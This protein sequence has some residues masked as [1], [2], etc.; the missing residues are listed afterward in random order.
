[1]KTVTR[2]TRCLLLCV[3]F[4]LPAQA[5]EIRPAVMTVAVESGRCSVE[6]TLNLEALLAGV[7]PE[8]RDTDQSPNSHEYASLRALPPAALRDRWQEFEAHF[9]AGMDIRADGRRL[10]SRVV[11]IEIPAIDDTRLAR[12]TRLKLE[13]DLP[14]SASELRFAYAAAFGSS[15]WRVPGADGRLQAVWLQ[16]GRASDA[17][18]IG[19][20]LRAP[21]RFEIATQ[22]TALGFTHILPKGLDHILFVLGL[23]LLGTTLAPLLWQ[24]TAFTVAHTIT[25]ALSMYGVVALSPALVEPLIAASIVVVAVE[26]MFT[27]R[28]H[29]WRVFVVFGFGLLHGLG[30][31]GVLSEIGLPREEFVTGLI[32]F[33]V[34]VEIGQLAVIAL[35]W[36]LLRYPFGAQPWYRTRVVLPLSALIALT[37]LYWTLERIGF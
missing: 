8:H 23:F 28:L 11:V 32:A 20:G 3:A 14:N 15:V 5:H 33:N 4:V 16:G 24:V 9:L 18:V 7:S 12:I 27:R 36:A 19:V 29:A 34:G 25:L 31:A 6:V 17:Y 30:F 26:N 10:P 2:F 37:G 22:Y 21:T 13:F 35:A 1:M